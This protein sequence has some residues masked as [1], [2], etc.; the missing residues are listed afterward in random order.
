MCPLAWVA[1]GVGA[2]G[3]VVGSVAGALGFADAGSAKSHC[4]G[5]VCTPEA[6]GPIA[7]A[8]SV[9]KVSDIGFVVAGVGAAVGV[10]LLVLGRPERAAPSASLMV[11]PTSFGVRATW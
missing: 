1:F 4:T 6:Q 9:A 10:G 7:D 8:K 3:L 2:A 11:G 5:N